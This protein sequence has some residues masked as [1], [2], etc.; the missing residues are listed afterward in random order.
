MNR[1]RTKLPHYLTPKEVDILLGAI[2][3]DRHRLGFALMSY[4]GLRV[5]E[6]CTLRVENV[7]LA[8]GFLRVVGKGNR[9][10]IVPL[11]STLQSHIERYLQKYSHTLSP[12]SLLVGLNRRTWWAAARRY[13]VRSLGRPIKNHTLRHSFATGL[14][15]GGV[16]LERI[17]QLLGHARLDTTMIY[18]HLSL[19]HKKEAVSALDRSR[20]RFL[21]RL[22]RFR[23]NP[24][25]LTVT[26]ATALIGRDRELAELNGRVRDGVS[27][28][29]YGAPG[30]GK[31]ALIRNVSAGELEPLFLAEYRKKQTL[32]AII[33]ASQNI[34]DPAV[35]RNAERE[36]KKLTVDELLTEI[37]DVRRVIVIDDI[38]EL[39]RTDRKVVARLA[40]CAVVVAASSR[41]RDKKLF[42]TYLELKPLR[43]HHTRIVISEMIHMNDHARKEHIV[44]DI[45]HSAGD[46]LREA[47][48]IASQLP[49]GK[50]PDEITTVERAENQVTIAPFLLM[51]VLFFVAFILKSYATSIVAFSYAMLVVFRLVF[52]KYLFS[53]AASRRKQA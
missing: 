39:S 14:Y 34:D 18:A 17:S 47:A 45:L 50:N 44:D 42:K 28:V 38:S 36:L 20:F 29:V 33:L 22:F 26:H 30:C 6:M 5:S 12:E 48:Y 15:D 32:I 25:D 51:V 10:R 37:K 9:E 16:Q 23:K 31:S 13:S 8:R 52:Y 1:H 2:R 7:N 27:V 19:A 24:P 53:P 4:A 43:R 11:S 35:R 21:R 40:E 41:D 49:L 3:K 46:N